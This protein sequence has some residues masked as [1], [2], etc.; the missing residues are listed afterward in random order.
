M[1]INLKK[2]KSSIRVEYLPQLFERYEL[3]VVVGGAV[4]IFLIAG[5]IFYQ[6][7]YK[8]VSADVEG[9][10]SIPKIET[11]LFEQVLEDLREKK[12][13]FPD[14]PIIDPFK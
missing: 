7:A 12:Q 9:E 4:F 3:F 11:A 13:P 10:V 1:R 5:F 6:N 14:E 8:T 2:L